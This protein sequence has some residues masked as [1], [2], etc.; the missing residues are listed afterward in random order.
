MPRYDENARVRADES[1]A[2]A[3]LVSRPGD[4]T[5]LRIAAA[6]TIRLSEDGPRRLAHSSGFQRRPAMRMLALPPSKPRLRQ[7]QL[8]RYLSRKAS[9]VAVPSL[10]ATPSQAVVHPA[11]PHRPTFIQRTRERARVL[12]LCSATSLVLSVVS[13]LGVVPSALSLAMSWTEL[14]VG[15]ARLS[16]AATRYVRVAIA[17]SALGVCAPGLLWVIRLSATM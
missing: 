17:L 3:R 10:V 4:D 13:P 12:M 5:P 15:W 11:V 14:N 8:L 7:A 9:T 6:P 1:S 16:P 2:R